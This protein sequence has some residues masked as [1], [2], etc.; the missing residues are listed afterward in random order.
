[1]AL[2]R[3]ETKTDFAAEEEVVVGTALEVT[4]FVVVVAAATLEVVSDED[5]E[6]TTGFDELGVAVDIAIGVEEEVN[7]GMALVVEETVEVAATEVVTADG[8]A[9]EVLR[10]VSNENR[11]KQI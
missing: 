3:E 11:T 4:A 6:L 9:V 8:L 7:T 1:V 10:N 5:D 2:V